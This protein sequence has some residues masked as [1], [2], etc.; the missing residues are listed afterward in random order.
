MPRAAA[1]AVGPVHFIYGLSDDPEKRRFEFSHYVAVRAAHTHLR[2][3]RLLFHCHH[4]PSGPWWTL[5]E[6]LVTVVV[7]DL[8]TE[9]FGR[10]LAHAAHRAD[11]LR[12]QLL[13]AQGGIYLDLDVV[14]VRPLAP[15]LRAGD[16]FVIG[17][18]GDDRLAFGAKFHGLCNA[19]MLARPNATFA[20]RWLSEYASFG[21]T[22][23]A[24]NRP[25]AADAWSGHS[26]ALPA[27]LA[28]AHP[29][30]VRVERHT[31]FFWPDWDEEP[32]RALLLYRDESHFRHRPFA[33]HLWGSLGAPFVLSSW[34][35][36]YLTSVP[37][38][39]NCR[40]QRALA[41]LPH[42][43]PVAIDGGAARRNCSCAED[44]PAWPTATTQPRPAAHWPLV[45]PRGGTKRLLV[46]ESGS[47]LHGWLYSGCVA[48]EGRARADGTRRGEVRGGVG[49]GAAA[50]CWSEGRGWRGA[51]QLRFG[52][53]ETPGRLLFTPPLDAFV[54]L[55]SGAPNLGTTLDEW[56]VSWWASATS[57]RP[58]D[59]GAPFAW[60]SLV[61][62]DGVITAH[63][64][65][66]AGYLLPSLSSTRRAAKAEVVASD[67]TV[68]SNGW[69]HFVAS[70]SAA[71]GRIELHVDGALLGSASWAPPRETRGGRQL[72]GLWIGGELR[73]ITSRK[74]TAGTA[75]RAI[76]VGMAD[77]ALFTSALKPSALPAAVTRPPVVV[78]SDWAPQPIAMPPRSAWVRLAAR[79]G[80]VPPHTGDATAG[81]LVMLPAPLLPPF[82][83]WAP[84]SVLPALALFLAAALVGAVFGRRLRFWGDVHRIR[85]RARAGHRSPPTPGSPK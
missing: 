25:W 19:V 37:S 27:A 34:S 43:P 70:G 1:A 72:L 42:A 28:A 48:P 38:A 46:D 55:P 69:H 22:S 44:A 17:R 82:G 23:T 24:R 57:L 58:H 66:A 76:A 73:P 20:R 16:A 54:P 12:L 68:C 53:A 39:L 50:G 79:W 2:P 45:A 32:L 80:T 81:T 85:L 29:S 35:P 59:C 77:L 33:F 47:C 26:V 83:R 36:E 6:P 4:R 62:A 8:P 5:A 56:T 41:P 84:L 64:R 75:T 11:V 18:E 60:W 49:G 7:V 40:L 9:I 15:L 30:E 14:V 78:A 67:V 65:P 74:P 61:F 51:A 13:L 10:P 52:G 71:T 21:D 63:A 3:A 31:A